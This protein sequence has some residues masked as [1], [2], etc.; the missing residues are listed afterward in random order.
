MKRIIKLL[1]LVMVL[2][3]SWS[4]ALY[5]NNPTL[6]VPYAGNSKLFTVAFAV[7]ALIM[8]FL[9]AVIIIGFK[10]SKNQLIEAPSHRKKEK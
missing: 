4:G 7:L 9:I 1:T 6:Q 3:Y 5:A 10:R 8:I 2:F